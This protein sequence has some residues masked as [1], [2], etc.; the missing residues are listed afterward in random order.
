[1]AFSKTIFMVMQEIYEIPVKTREIYLDCI[2]IVR[3]Y[4]RWSLGG[5]WTYGFLPMIQQIKST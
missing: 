1:M 4:S 5:N 3:N 2:K